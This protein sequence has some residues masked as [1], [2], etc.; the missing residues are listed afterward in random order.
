MF[1]GFVSFAATN[2]DNSGLDINGRQFS[3]SHRLVTANALEIPLQD[4]EA[5]QMLPRLLL[6]HFAKPSYS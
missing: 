4:L 5:L 1:L 2:P 6:G 3:F